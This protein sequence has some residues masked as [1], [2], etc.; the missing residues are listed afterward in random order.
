MFFASL[1]RRDSLFSPDLADGSGAS[2]EV[3]E[4]SDGI[5]PDAFV[6]V[7]EG[8]E[9]LALLRGCGVGRA[10]RASGAG[11]EGLIPV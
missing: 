2:L 11:L 6:C 4:G 7:L 1:T 5:G 9:F 8:D 10:A 3:L